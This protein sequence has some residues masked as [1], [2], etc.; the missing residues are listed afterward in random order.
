MGRPEGKSHSG[1]EAMQ[2][3]SDIGKGREGEAPLRI[4]NEEDVLALLGC[5]RCDEIV[6]K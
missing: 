1:S 5:Q 4:R 2:A 6:V 3:G